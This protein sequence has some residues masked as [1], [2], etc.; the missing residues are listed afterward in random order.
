MSTLG[1]YHVWKKDALESYFNWPVKWIPVC[2]HYVTL[3]AA[4]HSW[5]LLQAGWQMMIGCALNMIFL[6]ISKV[7]DP[8]QGCRQ[9][10]LSQSTR[11]IWK[12][13]FLSLGKLRWIPW[14]NSLVHMDDEVKTC[15]ATT[16]YSTANKTSRPVPWAL[17][18]LQP[19][20]YLL[21]YVW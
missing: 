5:L 7:Q 3:A 9:I 16:S 18:Y 11:I 2:L 6:F 1:G 14:E 13:H 12:T 21:E 4:E 10:Y 20:W 8:F 19:R 17:S 15:K